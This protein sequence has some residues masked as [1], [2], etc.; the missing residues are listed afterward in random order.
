MGNF[1]C[2]FPDTAPDDSYSY[3]QYDQNIYV[4]EIENDILEQIAV[5]QAHNLQP[6]YNDIENV[7]KEVLVKLGDYKSIQEKVKNSRQNY[8]ISYKN[9][10][11]RGTCNNTQK[12]IAV[13]KKYQGM[14]VSIGILLHE[15]I[16]AIV[17][18]NGKYGT[19]LDCEF[20]ENM[21]CTKSEGRTSPTRKDYKKFGRTLKN[22]A[23]FVAIIKMQPKLDPTDVE[24]K[25]QGK[26]LIF[27]RGKSV[28]F[29]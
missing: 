6:K 27:R 21:C 16:H 19:E 15:F 23:A 26:G 10:K 20:F 8:S 14:K 3:N 17:G 25:Y 12:V 22:G 7:F 2:G 11:Y 18:K 5:G 24:V 4:D 28:Q 29:V 9:M 13:N 1:P